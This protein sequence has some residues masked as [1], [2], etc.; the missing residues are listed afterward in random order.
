MI[1]DAYGWQF[2]NNRI[3][4]DHYASRANCRVI[5]PDFYDGTACPVWLLDYVPR[6]MDLYSVSN[7]LWIPYYSVLAVGALGSFFWN[8]PFS[9]VIPRVR[10]FIEAEKKANPSTSLGAAGYCYGGYVAFDLAH[11]VSMPV[12]VFFTA[13]PS[14]LKFPKD[15]EGL[16][17]PMAVAVGSKDEFV[18][19]KELQ[20]MREVFSKTEGLKWEVKVYVDCGHGFSVR[21]EFGP[22]HIEQADKAEKQAVTWFVDQFKIILA[23]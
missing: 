7:W 19:E 16:K 22:K 2:T 8:N 12:D 5:L 21:A 15:I 18:K 20:M 10:S 9:T 23:N 3:L 4:A 14:A 17:R 6:I 13:H 11:D 1:A